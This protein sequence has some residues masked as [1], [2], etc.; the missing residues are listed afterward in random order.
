MW[1]QIRS[2]PLMKYDFH[3]ADFHETDGHFANFYEDVL[4]SFSNIHFSFI[5]QLHIYQP[6][7]MHLKPICVLYY[8]ILYFPKCFDP[9]EPSSGRTKYKRKY[10]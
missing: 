4:P 5:K 8:Y 2:H 3:V 9:S 7:E 6:Y 1:I 10:A